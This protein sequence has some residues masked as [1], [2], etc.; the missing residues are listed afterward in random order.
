M[1][2]LKIREKEMRRIGYHTEEIIGLAKKIVYNYYPKTPKSEVLQLLENIFQ[3]PGEYK[4]H[5]HFGEL[6]QRLLHAPGSI[7][8]EIRLN[9]V[10][11]PYQVFGKDGIDEGS[12]KQMDLAMQ[13]PITVQGALMADAHRGYGLPIGGVLAA[14]NAVIPFGVGMDIGCRMSLSV[15][16]LPSVLLE[17]D[18]ERLKKILINE[19]RFGK[20]EFS[21]PQ[22][23]PVLEREEFK[24]I[25]FL[26]T[27]QL[28]AFHQLGT[29]GHGNHFVDLGVLEITD[30]NNAWNLPAGIYFAVLSHSG[31]RGMGAEIARHYTRIAK[32]LCRLPKGATT[33]SWLLLNTQEGQEYWKA[34]TLA[35]DYSAANHEQIHQRISKALGEKPLIKVENHHNF[36]WKEK[37]EKNEEVIV[38]RKGAT[39]AHKG[40]LGIIPGSMASP[41]FIVRGKGNTAS[42]NSAAH[43]AGRVFSRKAAKERISKKEMQSYLNQRGIT[44]I[45]GNTD[46]APQVYK[47]IYQV[48]EYQKDLVEVLAIFHPKIVRMA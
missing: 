6:A 5:E 39:P 1:K 11:L 42:I 40:T 15:Y 29:S 34:M 44:L 45:G 10:P 26:K 8:E 19:T 32:D 43:G 24:E 2:K 33:L 41:A 38:H 35:G 9:P 22:D 13:L 30:A 36:A 46:E 28:K 18:K 47:N 37:I 3:H 20:N 23:H 16:N 31:S 17:R 48:M 25:S 12:W 27:L 4:N 14:K 7:K 21:Q